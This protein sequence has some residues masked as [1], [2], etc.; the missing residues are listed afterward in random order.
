MPVQFVLVHTMHIVSISFFLI[1]SSRRITKKKNVKSFSRVSCYTITLSI[2]GL[3]KFSIFSSSLRICHN[4]TYALSM[5]TYYSTTKKNYRINKLSM[6]FTKQI[7][8]KKKAWK[9]KNKEIRWFREN[10]SKEK[11]YMKERI[12]GFS[13]KIEATTKIRVKRK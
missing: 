8:K 12:N 10:P 13:I 6:D 5:R 1:F 4:I 3:K 7:P 9:N 2:N 11:W